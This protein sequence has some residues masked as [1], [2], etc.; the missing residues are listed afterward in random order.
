[1]NTLRCSIKLFDTDSDGNQIGDD[2]NKPDVDVIDGYFIVMLDFGSGVFDGNNPWLEIGVR[3]GELND[4]NEYTVLSPLQQL[5]ATPYAMAVRPPLRLVWGGSEPT[6]S[7]I[8]TAL[9]RGIGVYGESAQDHAYGIYGKVT[10][11]DS[12]GVCGKATGEDGEA[13]FGNASG[14]ADRAVVGVHADTN[15][16]GI[17]GHRLYGV[18]GGHMTTVSYGSIMDPYGYI[19]G[20]I[21]GVYGSTINPN[22]YAGYFDGQTRV[23]KNLI[24]DCNVGIG[25]ISPDARLTLYDGGAN[26]L[27]NVGGSGNGKIKVRHVDGKSAGSTN[28][29]ELYLQHG[30]NSNTLINTNSTGNVGIGTTSPEFKLTLDNDG[31]IIAKGTYN[32][33]NDLAVSGLGTRLIWYPKKAAFRAG[34]VYGTQWD[35]ANIGT[36]STAM[37]FATTASG[38]CSTAMGYCTTAS[39]YCSTAIGRGNVGGGN[40]NTWV[41]S[42]PIFEIGIGIGLGGDDKENAVTVLK[43]GKVGIGTTSPT[44]KLFIAGDVNAVASVGMYGFPRAVISATNTAYGYGVYGKGILDGVHGDS[45]DG[46]GV[47]GHSNSTA[48]VSGTSENS[49]GVRGSSRGLNGYGVYGSSG[50]R[51]H[52]GVKGYSTG[53]YSA[54]VHGYNNSNVSGSGVY[55]ESPYDVGVR[56]SGVSYDFYAQGSGQDYGSSSSIRWKSDIEPIDKPLDKVISLRGVYFNWDKE[57]GGEHD[58]GMIA[59][60]VGE[61]LPEIVQYEPNSIYATGMDYSKLTPLLVEAVKALKAENDTLQKR[62][63]ALEIAEAENKSLAQRIEALEKIVL[64]QVVSKEVQ[65]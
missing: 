54:G 53:N 57:H 29:E 52:A 46:V 27:L 47:Y 59:E 12:I 41:G 19:G 45:D 17:L 50:A 33:G 38:Y 4:P 64:L 36:Y 60:E 37:G 44:A 15:T 3:P 25:T 14:D 23:T 16:W 22:N 30:V 35:N 11:H 9:N 65:Q 51:Y 31:G 63:N 56:A 55:G 1:M 18:Y 13:I 39:S 58:V 40:A 5:T 48:G 24:V 7:G 2:V 34:Y 61:V 42:D 20:A 8:A 32:S 43:S 26:Y 49:D 28:V 62:L 10:A 6:I 21:H